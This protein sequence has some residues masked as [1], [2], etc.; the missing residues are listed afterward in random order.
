MGGP[1][2]STPP[3]LPLAGGEPGVDITLPLLPRGVSNPL[4][5][6][7]HPQVFD[8]A[9]CMFDSEGFLMDSTRMVKKVT[10]VAP[11]C[12]ILLFSATFSD[13]VRAFA[14]KHVR[15]A[16]QVPPPG[17]RFCPG[18]CVGCQGGLEETT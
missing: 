13:T 17:S 2:Q 5:A 12:Q 15:R 6:L 1:A 4:S 14:V 7:L 3:S 16:N 8:E 18:E 10:E 11:Q 9:D